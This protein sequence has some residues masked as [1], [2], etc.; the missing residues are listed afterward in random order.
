VR[1]AL[2]GVVLAAGLC[3][4]VGWRLHGRMTAALGDLSREARR[5]VDAREYAARLPV[6]A[7]DETG[8]LAG[9]IND[10]LGQLQ[11]RDKELL[12]SRV[13]AEV[14]ARESSRL[15]DEMRK[16]NDE[17]AREV[18]FR[19]RAECALERAHAELE[20]KVK[21][22]TS[23]L[24]RS[25]RDLEQFAYVASHDLQEP[26]RTVAS[27]TQLI[28][29]RYRGRLD[30]DAEEYMDYIVD[31]VNRMQQLINALLN[32]SRVETR[33]RPFESTDCAKALADAVAALGPV[34]KETA[35]VIEHGD[36]PT[37]AADGKQLAQVFLNL[38]SNAIK[39]RS[40]APPRV[41]VSAT[42]DN[43]D[44]QFAVVDNGIGIAHEYRDRIFVIFQRLHTRRHY[45]G[46]GIGLAFCKKIVERHGGRIWV[47]SEEGK[48]S[49]FYF[50]I[51]ERRAGGD[52]KERSGQADRHTA[53]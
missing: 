43:G 2:A 16:A 34:I 4:F 53:G 23:E 47:E 17:L 32:Y 13:R 8:R 39:F 40:E 3:L 48:G 18:R 38:V 45:P 14:A 24:A 28:A 36:L 42:R 6:H 7:Q 25:N 49:T 10:M 11:E 30:A 44:W 37:V 19:E 31:G 12:H 46:T 27:Y 29:R 26:L 9:A 20:R 33:G 50:T 51:P 52:A 5:V 22:R 15:N 1:A 35:A 41:L 21:D